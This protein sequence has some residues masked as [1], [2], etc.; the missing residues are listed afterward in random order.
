MTGPHDFPSEIGV[1]YSMYT[2]ANSFA[3]FLIGLLAKKGL[4]AESYA[5]ML[6]PQ[7]AV[8]AE[9]GEKPGWPARYGLGFHMMNSPFGLA[10]GHG[11]HN[12]NFSCLFEV[13]PEHDMGFVV[14]TNADN[15]WLLAE[16]LREYLVI[17][18]AVDAEESAD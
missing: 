10:F 7:V 17:G 2:E 13:Y 4:S 6:E 5:L 8:P 15:G 14:F 18:A 3:N 12:G 1:A 16:S 11:G 9:P